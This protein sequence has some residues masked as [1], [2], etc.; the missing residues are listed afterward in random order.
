M[1]TKFQF[2]LMKMSETTAIQTL[3]FSLAHSVFYCLVIALR[4]VTPVPDPVVSSRF[5]V[6]CFRV[7]PG[8]RQYMLPASRAAPFVQRSQPV[9]YSIQ[10]PQQRYIEAEQIYVDEDDEEQNY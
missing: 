3:H 5:N 7:T 9:T 2:D 8:G 1:C 6:C 10:A 4:T